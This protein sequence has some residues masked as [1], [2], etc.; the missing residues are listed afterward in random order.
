[1]LQS[2]NL[3][4]TRIFFHPHPHYNLKN[5]HLGL[6]EAV[7]QVK[8]DIFLFLKDISRHFKRNLKTTK[9]F[10]RKKYQFRSISWMD[11]L[12]MDWKFF[13]HMDMSTRN[14]NGT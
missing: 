2:L 4:L 12:L 8:R 3:T 1:M 6:F 9:K 14:S 10:Y 13:G 11:I 7:T 5:V